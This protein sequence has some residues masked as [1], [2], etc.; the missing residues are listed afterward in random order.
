MCDH[1][2]VQKYADMIMCSFMYKFNHI[3]AVVYCMNKVE[4]NWWRDMFWW[5]M[6]RQWRSGH[7]CGWSRDTVTGGA[8]QYDL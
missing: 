5:C 6:Y 1:I 7:W 8:R 3:S 2:F 4:L